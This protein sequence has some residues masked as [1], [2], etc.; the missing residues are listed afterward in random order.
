[1]LLT[2]PCNG[3]DAMAPETQTR[4]KLQ[5]LGTGRGQ[6]VSLSRTQIEEAGFDPDAHLEANR[7]VFDS[8]EIRIRL[9][10]QEKEE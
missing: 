8:G 4:V 2:S 9:Y 5:D 6:N 1:M 3:L 10:E 7:Y